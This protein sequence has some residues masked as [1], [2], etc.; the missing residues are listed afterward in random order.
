M[1]TKIKNIIPYIVV[2]SVTLLLIVVY[3]CSSHMKMERKSYIFQRVFPEK[4]VIRIIRSEKGK[5]EN[6]KGCI[7]LP[8][9][10]GYVSNDSSIALAAVIH[11]DSTRLSCIGFYIFNP[12]SKE[13]YKDSCIKTFDINGKYQNSAQ[14][15]LAFNGTFHE[16]DEYITYTCHYIP[17]IYVF[18]RKGKFISHLQTMDK[19]PLPSVIKYGDYYILDRSKA[20]TTNVASVVCK[21]K[22]YVMSLL[23][24]RNVGK[25]VLDCY[26]ISNK[27][28]LY[29]SYVENAAHE[30]NYLV[31]QFN[32][33]GN[34]LTITTFDCKTIVKL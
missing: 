22:L 24:K 28:Y 27:S 20:H 29:S 15:Q 3:L 4:G 12:S 2:L 19:T 34:N 33:T 10:C 1:D 31:N 17:D 30:D 26:D 13:I 9:G 32:L 8:G 6:K 5:F 18:D 11:S 14:R 21:G 7:L 25:Y 23:T 16:S